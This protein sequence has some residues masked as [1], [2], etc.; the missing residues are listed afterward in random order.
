MIVDPLFTSLKF[1][2]IDELDELT[3]VELQREDFKAH[4]FYD[5]FLAEGRP[6]VIRK[7]A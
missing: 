2:L 7:Y 3:P 5:H 6:L 1:S 4:A